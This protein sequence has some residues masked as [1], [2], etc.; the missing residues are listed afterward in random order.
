VGIEV[1]KMAIPHSSDR[2]QQMTTKD[3]K[4]L[5]ATGESDLIEFKE[6]WYDLSIKEGKA[7]F[8]KDVLALANT[9]RPEAPGHLLIGVDD[10]KDVVG[11]SDSPSAEAISQIISEYTDPPVNV[12]CRDYELDR[13][14]LSVLAVSWAPA[15]PHRSV[16][17]YPEILSSNVIY[18]RRD[19]IIG[20]LTLAE[21]ETRFREK[22][23]RWGPL[24]RREPI[25]FGFV[26]TD[27]GRGSGLV[28]RVSNV[29]T[30]PVG[31]VDVMIDVRNARD[32]RLFHRARLLSNATLGPGESREVE[33]KA[34]QITF[35]VPVIEPKA[36]EFTFVTVRD[37]GRHVG[38]RWLDA[39]LHV[40]YRDRDGFIRHME[41]R[42]AVEM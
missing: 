1:S 11:V 7:V 3:L 41:Q 9:V 23:A 26:Q 12:H 37:F 33:L 22:D 27:P 2:S 4:G 20:T 35:Y 18:V 14:K 36:D 25:Q 13:K 19:R 42:V 17:D 28:A 34:G 6:K 5:I 8:V 24:V 39:T 31:G 40:D 29:T 16:R 15:N 32:P 30:E 21:I 10:D 38:E